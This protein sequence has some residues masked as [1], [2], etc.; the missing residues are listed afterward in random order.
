MAC[1]LYGKEY[2]F[3]STSA[4]SLT[5]I[6]G[7]IRQFLSNVTIRANTANVSNVYLG[8]SD[9]TAL[10]NRYGFLLPGESITLE[11]N[12]FFGTSEPYLVGAAGDIIHIAGLS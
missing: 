2:V 12:A 4:V 10:A 1:A 3:P 7:G 11:V 5:T 6:L 9:V 8:A